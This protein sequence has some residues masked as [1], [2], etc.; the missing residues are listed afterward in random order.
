MAVVSGILHPLASLEPGAEYARLPGFSLAMQCQC[1]VLSEGIYV[2]VGHK[3]WYRDKF[4]SNGSMKLWRVSLAD[5]TSWAPLT[6]YLPKIRGCTLS[7]YQSH[8]VLVGGSSIKGRTL[9][10]LWVSVDGTDWEKSLPRMPTARYGVAAVNTGRHPERLIVA[11][12]VPVSDKVEV[13]EEKKWYSLA[14]LPKK[15]D[16]TSMTIHNGNIYIF[17][18]LVEDCSEVTPLFCR[19][20]SLLA[21]RDQAGVRVCWNEIPKPV[22]DWRMLSTLTSFQGNLLAFYEYEDYQYRVFAYSPARRFW[23][24][25][26]KNMYTWPE[27]LGQAVPLPNG[28]LFIPTHSTGGDVQVF[29]TELK[30]RLLLVHCKEGYQLIK[31]QYDTVYAG[32]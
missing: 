4:F 19:L 1:V 24:M 21:T 10:S 30:G 27:F 22:G 17:G 32:C 2:M 23:A 5:L 26:R 16:F 20:D 9:S 11:G 12:G 6:D 8:L 25:V 28:K 3:F 29:E 7:T 31:G 15:S 18:S 13:L 14:P